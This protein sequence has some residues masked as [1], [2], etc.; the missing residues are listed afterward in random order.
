MVLTDY[1][2]WVS[3]PRGISG[4]FKL[5]YNHRWNITRGGNIWTL[6]EAFDA[7][8]DGI[9]IKVYEGIYVVTYNPVAVIITVTDANKNGA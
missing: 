1:H 7:V 3:P 4:K 9:N 2:K 5:R 6:G 8:A